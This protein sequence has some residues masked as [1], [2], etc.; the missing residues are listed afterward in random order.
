M[1]YLLRSGLVRHN[2]GQ[3]C[4]VGVTWELE[5]LAVALLVQRVLGQ[6]ECSLVL[7]GVAG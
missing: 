3:S 7:G 4:C 6:G 1:A 2:H 5:P